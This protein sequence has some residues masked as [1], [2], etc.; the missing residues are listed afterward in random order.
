MGEVSSKFMMGV[1]PTIPPVPISAVKSRFN[2]W[3][4][5][6]T[7]CFLKSRLYTKS[8][9]FIERFNFGHKILNLK[10]RLFVKSIIVKSRL[11]CIY[12]A[13]EE[14]TFAFQPYSIRSFEV[15]SLCEWCLW[16]IKLRLFLKY[17]PHNSHSTLDVLVWRHFL[18]RLKF[19]KVFKIFPQSSHLNADLESTT[20]HA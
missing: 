7:L 3:P 5:V 4:P 17:L 8:R 13:L 9:L 19:L 16:A 1:P 12:L 6:S 18:C 11:Y 20:K 10:S 2:E 15:T 14:M